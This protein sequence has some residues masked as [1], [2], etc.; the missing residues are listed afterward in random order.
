MYRHLVNEIYLTV[1]RP[2]P[3][4]GGQIGA[5]IHVRQS[6]LGLSTVRVRV[7]F[8]VEV[9]VRLGLALGLEIRL[10]DMEL[11]KVDI[12]VRLSDLETQH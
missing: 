1:V 9:R 2:H 8:R 12:R 3:K 7:W 6:D 11:C 5:T 10:S 4:V